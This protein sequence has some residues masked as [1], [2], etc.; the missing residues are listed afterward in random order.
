MPREFEEGVWMPWTVPDDDRQRIGAIG[1]DALA[2]GDTGGPLG[3]DEWGLCSD[4]GHGLG[5][6]HGDRWCSSEGD[7]L[8]SGGWCG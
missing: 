7:G 8:G 1:R 6:G 2:P 5:F 4:D 3:G